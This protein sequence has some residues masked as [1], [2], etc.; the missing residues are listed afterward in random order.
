MGLLS[1]LVASSDGAAVAQTAAIIGG[2]HGLAR[3][4]PAARAGRGGRVSSTAR[5]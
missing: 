1:K 3:P 4:R 5:L 2:R